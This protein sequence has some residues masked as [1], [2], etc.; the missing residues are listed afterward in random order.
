M[1]LKVPESRTL[2]GIVNYADINSDMSANTYEKDIGFYFTHIPINDLGTSFGFSAEYRLNISG[3][4]K[5]NGVNLGISYG[6][7]LKTNCK[8]LWMKNPKCFDEDTGQLR[9]DLYNKN[10]NSVT[11]LGL[12]YD[13]I[14]DKFI[15]VKKN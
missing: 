10:T 12:V 15:P 13:L 8:F 5:N 3:Q 6:K 14:T 4:S 11:A 7:K 9:T 2:D 1:N